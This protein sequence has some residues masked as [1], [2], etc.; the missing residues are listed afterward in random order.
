MGALSTSS[1]SSYI[2]Y[3]MKWHQ[4][5]CGVGQPLNQIT[6]PS[7]DISTISLFCTDDSGSH[8]HTLHILTNKLPA[9]N[10][11]VCVC[12]HVSNRGVREK[13]RIYLDIEKPCLQVG[14]SLLTQ[15]QVPDHQV[16]R[17]VSEETLVHCRHAGLAANVPYIEGH[18]VLLCATRQGLSQL[19]GLDSN[20]VISQKQSN[21]S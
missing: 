8:S 14:H 10:V 20:Q 18:R 11:C 9:R 17:L 2:K 1:T 19:K 5:D 16:Q 4:W 15:S 12:L 13:E 3:V 6:P 21:K 7:G